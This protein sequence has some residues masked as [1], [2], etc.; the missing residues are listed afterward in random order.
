MLEP[1]CSVEG[2]SVMTLSWTVGTQSVQMGTPHLQRNEDRLKQGKT[3][4]AE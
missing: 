1:R 2:G 3:K 4:M